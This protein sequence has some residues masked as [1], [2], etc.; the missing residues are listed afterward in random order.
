MIAQCSDCAHAASDG[1][2]DEG[3]LMKS[4]PNRRVGLPGLLLVVLLSRFE[5]TARCEGAAIFA[6]PRQEQAFHFI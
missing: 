1:K 6:N 2:G 4:I 3:R 5:S